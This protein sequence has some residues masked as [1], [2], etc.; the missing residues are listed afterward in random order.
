MKNIFHFQHEWIKLSIQ[1]ETVITSALIKATQNGSFQMN[2]E[3]NESNSKDQ[4]VVKYLN[5]T[6]IIYQSLW[7]QGYSL[8][9]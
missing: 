9:C 7:I 5:K 1:L 2:C 8:I 4:L 6:D 3:M